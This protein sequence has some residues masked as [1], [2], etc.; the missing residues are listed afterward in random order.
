MNRQDW[1]ICENVQQGMSSRV[2]RTGYYAPME[3]ASQDIRRY[4]A[5][6]LGADAVT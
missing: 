5:E 6:K 2:F 1:R 3:D 4:I